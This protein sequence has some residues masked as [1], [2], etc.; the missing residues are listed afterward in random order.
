MYSKS[1]N[2]LIEAFKYLPG[3]GEKSAERFVFH[4][5]NM[6]KSKIDFFI[7]SMKNLKDKIH[8]CPICGN[9]TEEKMCSICSSKDRN[10]ELLCVVEDPKTIFL[11]EKLGTFRGKYHVLN[12]LISPIDGINPEDI[13]LDKLIDRIKKENFKEIILAVK[14]SIEGETT[15]LYIKTILDGMDLKVSRIAS[16]IPLGADIEYIDSLTLERA[17]NERREIS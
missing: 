14:P 7:E 10:N 3:I 9:Y 13:K 11:I 4:M 6:D 1:I 2:D 15:S 16:G 8:I 5:L 12:G 17:I